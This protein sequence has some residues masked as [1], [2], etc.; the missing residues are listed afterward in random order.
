MAIAPTPTTTSSTLSRAM[1]WLFAAAIVAMVAALAMRNL[2]P[3]VKY[4]DAMLDKA[5]DTALALLVV[6]LFVERSMGVL[7]ALLFGE[8]QRE[9]QKLRALAT[10]AEE[11]ARATD[12]EARVLTMKERVRLL[13]G[14]GV[15]LFIS[16][17]GVRTLQGIMDGVPANATGAQLFY[18]VDIV[19]TAGLIAGGSNGLAFLLQLLKEL[20]TK[21]QPSDAQ[22]RTRMTT[23]S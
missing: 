16:A 20:S 13:V 11:E 18:G 12:E 17:A 3:G 15:A 9:A 21:S 7:N 2:L 19:L 10:T 6:T 14:F 1:G 8:Q 22:M 23:T 5:I 4:Q